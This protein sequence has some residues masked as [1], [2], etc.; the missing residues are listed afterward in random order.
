MIRWL[1]LVMMA[2]ALVGAV[3]YGKRRGI[4]RHIFWR[5]VVVVWGILLTT[6][7]VALLPLRLPSTA[8]NISNRDIIFVL[9]I[10][11]SMNAVDGRSG[12]EST[13]IDDMRQDIK[14][15]AEANV[16]ASMGMITFS[17]I[18]SLYLPLTTGS[19]DLDSAAD[20]LYTATE[21][22]A[23]NS[24]VPYTEVFSMLG[25]Y[26]ETQQQTDP[27]RERVVVMMSDF[28]IF[29]NQEQA[30]DIIQAARVIPDR[31]GAF[32]G[33]VYGGTEP[34]KMLNMQFDHQQGNYVPTYLT[35]SYSRYANDESAAERIKYLQHDYKTA[36]SS[37]NPELAHQLAAQL[38][39]QSVSATQSQEFA[40]PIEAASRRSASA[41]SQDTQA[42][43]LRQ[44]TLYI[45]PAF[46]GFVWLVALEI[47]KS[48]WAHRIVR[49][50]K[51]TK[52][53]AP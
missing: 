18:T 37:A 21:F 48:R 5:R 29:G 10:T 4:D 50:T 25:E 34:A 45:I 20:T 40:Q 26:L 36:Y 31:G 15:I 42:Q 53:Q 32:V 38:R 27:T 33:L 51:P 47:V 16:G 22:Q 12:N 17:D 23:I 43:A 19:D 7:A 2:A 44:N 3:L 49:P 8:Q 46:L 30:A 41:A 6:L 39:G 24:V 28:E 1:L 11:L 9:D 35:S 14:A 52:E 13:R